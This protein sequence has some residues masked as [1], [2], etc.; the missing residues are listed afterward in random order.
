MVTL[1]R[2]AAES[3]RKRRQ[4]KYTRLKMSQNDFDRGYLIEYTDDPSSDDVLYL[5][6]G[7]KIIVDSNT[8]KK[9]D[10]LKVDYVGKNGSGTFVFSEK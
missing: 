3:I 5:S 8:R 6:Y 2:A 10:R 4:K 7:I 9:F 1:T